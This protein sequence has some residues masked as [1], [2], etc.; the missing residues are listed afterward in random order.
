M[1]ETLRGDQ[2][3]PTVSVNEAREKVRI[4]VK[5]TDGLVDGLV[6]MVVGEADKHHGD[7]GNEAVFVNIV[8]EID[9][10]ELGRITKK[11]NIDVDV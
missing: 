5:Q 3:Q 2:W 7:T 9:P 10:A 6:V 8:G 4:F 1:T 11:L